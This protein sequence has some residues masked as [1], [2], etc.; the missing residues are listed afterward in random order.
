MGLLEEWG[1]TLSELNEILASRPSLRGMLMGFIA[2]YKLSQIW[3]TDP[4]IDKLVMYD[5]HDRTRPGD[6]GF[7]YNG[8]PV[9]VQVKSVQTRSI[10]RTEAGYTGAFQCDASDRRPVTL[11]NGQ[12]VETTCLVVGGFDLLAVNLFEF[13]QKWRFAFAKNSDLPRTR[14][15]RYT[16]EQ[17]QYLLA[18]SV[19]ITWPLQP[20]FYEEPFAVLDKIV[21]QRRESE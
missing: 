19:R 10:R 9:S 8:V 7:L 2:E 5:N 20:P 4:R 13:E 11:P 14:S 3:F 17:R 16:P 1:V 6:L 15:S 18:T 21:A 12:V